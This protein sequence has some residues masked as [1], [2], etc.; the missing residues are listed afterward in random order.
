MIRRTA[1]GFW[2]IDG[3][4]HIGKWIEQGGMTVHGDAARV[5]ALKHIVEE[6]VVIDVGCNVGWHAHHYATAVG[7]R[8]AV[9]GFDPNPEAIACAIRNCAHPAEFFNVAC[10]DVPGKIGLALAPNVG[11]SHLTP[12]PQQHNVIEVEVVRLDDVCAKLPDVAL[13]K[14]DAEGYELHVLRGA[15]AL[16][17]KFRP[18]LVIEINKG[19]LARAGSD[20]RDLLT[21]LQEWNYEI[22]D[23]PGGS[24][25]RDEQLDIICT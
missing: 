13:I 8:G 14:I 19:A 17:T 4:S 10:G 12:L 15:Q 3:D 23:L 18:Y 21:L 1:G 11:A 6:D 2:I 20:Y 16:I 24:L 7:P 5:E 9:L 22:R 25:H